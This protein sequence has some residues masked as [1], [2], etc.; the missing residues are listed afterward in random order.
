[1]HQDVLSE[2][3]CGEGIPRWAA[4]VTIDHISQQF[5]VPLESTPYKTRADDGFPTRQDCAKHEWASYYNTRAASS[6]FENLYTNEDILSKWG[7]FWSKVASQ[8]NNEDNDNN[9]ILGYELINEPFAGDIFSNPKLY[10]PSY[11]DS[12]RL[13]PAYDSLVDSIR[14][15]D[16]ETLVLFAAVTWDDVVPVGFSRPPGGMNESY[17]SVLAY[18]YYEPPQY[19]MKVYFD[20]RNRDLNRLE[21]GGMLTEFER[22]QAN[23][24]KNDPFYST[25][26]MADHHLLSWT[27]WE[28]KSFCK[29]TNETIHSNSQS[30]A[31]GSCKTGYGE[32]LIWDE[33][34]NQNMVASKKLA[35]SY[36]QKTSGII[37]HMSFNTSSSDFSLE[38]MIDV[39][40]MSKYPTEIFVHQSLHYPNGMQIKIE[41]KIPSFQKFKWEF[42]ST[43]IIGISLV[44]PI[45]VNN[46]DI[47]QISIKNN[48]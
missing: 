11:A 33:Y 16:Q 6:A 14:L 12:H 10:L 42:L 15:V 39:N 9:N 48:S 38:F 27:M 29:E 43:N 4:D 45:T 23:E 20:Q 8:F 44:M 3:F 31:F 41:S 2:K 34:G 30:A 21:V 22:P 7:Q 24:N 28:Y 19:N 25:A 47:I 46:N 35:R 36:A 40:I 17:R 18:H 13:L 32:Q 26:D 5:P 1:M 37:T